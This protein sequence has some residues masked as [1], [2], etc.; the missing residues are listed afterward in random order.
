VQNEVLDLA[1]KR[2]PGLVEGDEVAGDLD[3][4]ITKDL[5]FTRK[6]R[7][8][9]LKNTAKQADQS[10]LGR[11]ILDEVRFDD[12]Q[13]NV[14]IKD[15]Q[16]RT[17]A[18]GATQVPNPARAKP[19]GDPRTAVGISVPANTTRNESFVK[20]INKFVPFHST[21]EK[22]AETGIKNSGD[23]LLHEFTHALTFGTAEK[24]LKDRKLL[25]TL[26]EA[27]SLLPTKIQSIIDRTDGQL[28]K[29]SEVM[30]RIMDQARAIQAKGAAGAFNL[31]PVEEDTLDIAEMI[32]K[33]TKALRAAIKGARS[34]VEGEMSRA[35]LRTQLKT[36]R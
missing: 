34:E 32:W 19:S 20:E 35:A 33:D 22:F 27:K 10:P 13:I 28:H 4:F 21:P 18:L 3:T 26:F 36:G 2:R 31:T 11:E 15:P 16:G 17:G 30:A 12:S 14:I 8:R 6:E 1:V 9:L 24:W 25:G 5:S 23:V 29:A 7:N